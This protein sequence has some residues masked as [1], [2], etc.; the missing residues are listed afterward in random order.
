MKNTNDL[1]YGKCP[2]CKE[3]KH[4]TRYHPK[5]AKKK[6]REKNKYCEK[7]IREVS[8]E[9]T[10][11]YEL[12][13]TI[14]S[15]RTSTG[16]GDYTF[17]DIMNLHKQQGCKCAYCGANIP[18]KASLDHIIP[19]KF[20]GRNLLNNIILTCI[21]CNSAKQ[22]FEPF[23]FIRRK[24]YLITEFNIKRMRGAYDAHDYE[25]SATCE[26]CRG[27]NRKESNPACKNCIINPGRYK[28]QQVQQV[29][30]SSFAVAGA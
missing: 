5:D 3:W 12:K 15:H 19:K 13:K 6:R 24:G 10:P 20:G 4:L 7:C 28:A 1:G 25:C 11:F 29:Q 17:K 2:G 23:F 16:E 18:Y 30:K 21:S 8:N 14:A 26:D 22:H 27:K 9:R